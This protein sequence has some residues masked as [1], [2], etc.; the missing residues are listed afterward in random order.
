[1][2]WNIIFFSFIVLLI[3][4]LIT[5]VTRVIYAN[6][7]DTIN[8]TVKLSICGNEVAEGGEDCDH[9][10]FRGVNCR[11]LGYGGGILKC[12]ISCSFDKYDCIPLPTVTPT[13]LPITTLTP[14][15]IRIS[16]IISPLP[17]TSELLISVS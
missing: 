5:H 14:T 4:S 6:N 7:T 8:A 10:D 15:P 3:I 9:G 1:M 13:I 17:P 12:D 16:E 11:S 2:K